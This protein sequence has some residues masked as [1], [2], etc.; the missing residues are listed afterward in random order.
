[1][2]NLNKKQTKSYKKT[3]YVTMVHAK[4]PSLHKHTYY[5]N[6]RADRNLL[7]KEKELIGRKV[8]EIGTIV[9]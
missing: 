8:W 6:N 5:F 1:M 3:Y 2:K 7:I 9:E 4:I